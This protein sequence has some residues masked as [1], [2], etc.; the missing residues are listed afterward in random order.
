MPWQDNLNHLIGKPVGVSFRDGMGTSGI[1]CGV[2]NN[3][4]YIVEYLYQKQFATKQYSFNMVRDVHPF[5]PCREHHP[6]RSPNR[7]Y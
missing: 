1:L 4:L 7:L 5:P 6:H 2:K 3:T